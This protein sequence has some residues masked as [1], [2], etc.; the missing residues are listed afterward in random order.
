MIFSLLFHLALTPPI[1]PFTPIFSSLLLAFS[2]FPSI[3]NPVD[4][5][6]APDILY[7]GKV[8]TQDQTPVMDAGVRLYGIKPDQYITGAPIDI[9]LLAETKTGNEGKFTLTQKYAS[10]DRYED[11]FIIIQKDNFALTW[12]ETW[13]LMDENSTIT[14]NPAAVLE[15]RILDQQENAVDQATI[16]AVILPKNSNLY[17]RKIIQALASTQALTHHT[18]G[19]GRF[20]YN[21][22][23]EDATVEF[24][25]YDPQQ[26]YRTH[27]TWNTRQGLEKGKYEA[28]ARDILLTVK[29]G[30]ILSGQVV[31]IDTNKP[32]A[33]FQVNIASKRSPQSPNKFSTS[34]RT[35]KQGNF[36][37]LC[38]PSLYSVTLGPKLIPQEI[39]PPNLRRG[40]THFVCDTLYAPMAPFGPMVRV[41]EDWVAQSQQALV[42]LDQTAQVTLHAQ[43]AAILE[44]TVKDKDTHKNIHIPDI[45]VTSKSNGKTYRNSSSLNNIYKYYLLPGEYLIQHPTKKGY[46]T[47]QASRS[48][49]LAENQ[50]KQVN[51]QLSKNISANFVQGTVTDTQGNPVSNVDVFWIPNG[52]DIFSSD[53]NGKFAIPESLLLPLT[54]Y[55]AVPGN[56]FIPHLV[57]LHTKKHLAALHPLDS[58]K[59]LKIKMLDDLTLIG[60]VTDEH[61][62]PLSDAAIYLEIKGRN[63]LLDLDSSALY[64]TAETNSQGEYS[65]SGL[66]RGCYYSIRAVADET[67]GEDKTQIYADTHPR[68]ITLDRFSPYYGTGLNNS[69]V[70]MDQKQFTLPDLKLHPSGLAVSGT[71]MDYMGNSV[72]DCIV[73]VSGPGQPEFEPAKTNAQGKFRIEGLIAGKVRL[74][75]YDT[76]LMYGVTYCFVPAGSQDFHVILTPSGWATPRLPQ[77]IKHGGLV[78]IQVRDRIST[79]LISDATVHIIGDKI[80]NTL[81]VRTNKNGHCFIVL[82]SGSYEITEVYRWKGYKTQKP[83]KY[84]TVVDGQRYQFDIYMDRKPQIAGILLDEN[85]L[86]VSGAKIWIAPGIGYMHVDG[87]VFTTKADGMFRFSWDPYQAVRDA[88]KLNTSPYLMISHE[89]RN[90]SAHLKLYKESHENLEIVVKPAPTVVG[91]VMDK[92]GNT[93]SGIQLRYQLAGP[94]WSGPDIKHL[95]IKSD[96]QGEFR[97][98]GLPPLPANWVYRV[99]VNKGHSTFT[100]DFDIKANE[101]IPGQTTLKDVIKTR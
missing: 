50:T 65:F 67:R 6:A 41:E 39:L 69:C 97:I 16:H 4:V 58:S 68:V 79:D 17:D 76:S 60:R 62:N 9:S 53:E 80:A 99:S 72:V 32:M 19:A 86:P 55:E 37:V 64:L 47:T 44:I 40:V 12:T 15:G 82:P 81:Q 20:S 90:L 52:Q 24:V 45:S 98:T 57:F 73:R 11:E 18:D 42:Q 46:E 21:N 25:V 34:C 56:I 78:E 59:Q 3:E 101:L 66:P 27:R 48:V 92:N 10:S 30:S 13:S 49:T 100:S 83:Q 89:R 5:S 85:R 28:G 35:D 70:Y 74:T 23:P 54:T 88:K 77:Q 96:S 51:F 95:E 2:S 84:F 93:F 38:P 61:G 31:H 22:I 87:F 63:R 75:V 7:Q 36:S 26:R 1:S 91:A 33:E 14:M 43:K 71:V 29:K 94:K 8:I